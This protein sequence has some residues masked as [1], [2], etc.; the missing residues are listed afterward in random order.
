MSFSLY[1]IFHELSVVI[2]AST[3]GLH[4]TPP[5]ALILGLFDSNIQLLKTFK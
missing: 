1:L 2:A 4:R 5:H 3:P